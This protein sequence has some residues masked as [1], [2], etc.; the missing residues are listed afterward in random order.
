MTFLYLLL[1]ELSTF[2]SPFW[3]PNTR[4]QH[5]ITV[6]I[7][8]PI[9]KYELTDKNKVPLPRSKSKSR[10]KMIIDE[11]QKKERLFEAEPGLLR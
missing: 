3:T 8:T 11:I 6:N 10:N 4:K 1:E 5:T 7:T 2:S 9:N